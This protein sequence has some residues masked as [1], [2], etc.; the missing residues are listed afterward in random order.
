MRYDEW[1]RNFDDPVL[2]ELVEEA[3]RLNPGV[4]TAGMRILEARAQL[5]IAGSGLYPQLQQ[6]HGEGLYVGTA[7][8][9]QPERHFWSGAV[10]LDV[11]W[12]LDF[13][14]KFRRGIES[15]D[16]GYFASIAQYDDLQVLVA[17]Q[18]AIS[19]SRFAPSNSGCASRTRTPP[20][21]SAASRSPSDCSAAATSP[22]STCSSS[23]RS[24]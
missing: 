18:A 2:E 19:Y 6:A 4:R 12:E 14:G 1:W 5:G 8:S 10:G 7:R 9:E 21:R 3:Q 22:S 16:A 13:W 20:C 23:A 24:T 15:A 17:A 11:G